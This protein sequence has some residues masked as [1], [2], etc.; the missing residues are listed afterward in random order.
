MG[1]AIVIVNNMMEKLVFRRK[2]E[3]L[4]YLASLLG[5]LIWHGRSDYEEFHL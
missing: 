5:S 4:F 1:K 3:T 2:R